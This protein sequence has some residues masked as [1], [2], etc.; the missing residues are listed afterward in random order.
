VSVSSLTPSH[1]EHRRDPPALP[2]LRPPQSAGNPKDRRGR[3][4]YSL[5]QFGFTRYRINRKFRDQVGS[6]DVPQGSPGRVQ[7]STASLRGTR[8]RMKVSA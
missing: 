6:N 7:K 4:H 5:Q 1:A 2:H 3:H 8:R